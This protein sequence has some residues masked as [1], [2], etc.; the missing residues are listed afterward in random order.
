MID[1]LRQR[2]EKEGRIDLMFRVRP[3]AAQSQ[4]IDILD[5]G[6]V[7]IDIAAPA[8]DGKGNIALCK[9]I[10]ELFGVPP[11]NVK[12]LSGKTAR[13]KLVRITLA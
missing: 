1:A 13:L 2:L 12:I 11:L 4:F 6:S 3:H 9:F 8:E 5:D 10:G 7:K